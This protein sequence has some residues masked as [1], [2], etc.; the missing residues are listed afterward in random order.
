MN[1]VGFLCYISL[2][3]SLK[4]A[5]YT[6]CHPH[7]KSFISNV[8][9]LCGHPSVFMFLFRVFRQ[10]N[11][12]PQPIGYMVPCEYEEPISPIYGDGTFLPLYGFDDTFRYV[13]WFQ[14]HRVVVF[15]QRGRDKTWSDF[16]EGDVS[17]RCGCQLAQCLDIGALESLRGGVGGR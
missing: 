6:F 16:R 7:S 4:Y 13:F 9:G 8:I 11:P 2:C 14:Q 5:K 3:E 1:E 15:E 17:F 12:F 10:I